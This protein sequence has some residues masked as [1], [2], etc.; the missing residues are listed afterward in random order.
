MNLLVPSGQE[1]PYF[2]NENPIHFFLPTFYISRVK[3]RE[4]PEEFVAIEGLRCKWRCS[5]DTKKC[6]KL[7]CWNKPTICM[8][9]YRECLKQDGDG[10]CINISGKNEN[11]SNHEDDN[12]F[13]YTSTYIA[14]NIG[15]PYQSY[16]ITSGGYVE[17]Y[18]EEKRWSCGLQGN[19]VY[20]RYS[21]VYSTYSPMLL[22]TTAG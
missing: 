14:D 4:F 1:I 18:S 16:E 3:F 20:C 21:I 10:L 7:T 11:P 19:V 17:N 8:G 22:K 12:Y 5:K 2:D 9:D 13:E 15:L 6:E